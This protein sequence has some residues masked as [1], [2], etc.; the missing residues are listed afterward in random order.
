L[1]RERKRKKRKK[2]EI[3][4]HTV[5]AS[6]FILCPFWQNITNSKS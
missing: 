2:N 4:M 1:S 3:C 5:F 6:M